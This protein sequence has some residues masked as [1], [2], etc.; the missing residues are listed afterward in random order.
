MWQFQ[1]NKEEF[2]KKLVIFEILDRVN[3]LVMGLRDNYSLQIVCFFFFKRQGNY[4]ILFILIRLEEGYCRL[5]GICKISFFW[6]GEFF[7]VL[8]L[9]FGVFVDK[10]VLEFFGVSFVFQ[11]KGKFVLSRIGCGLVK[12]IN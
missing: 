11:F 7:Q 6:D 8:V 12:K 5:S 1:Q 9:D 2:I 3:K 4:I 10:G